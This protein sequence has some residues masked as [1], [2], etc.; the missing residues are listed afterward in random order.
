MQT[1]AVKVRKSASHASH[2]SFERKMGTFQV[3]QAVANAFFFPQKNGTVVN[4]IANINRGFAGMAHTG[5]ARAGVDNLTKSLSVEWAR[6]GIRINS[7]APGIIDSSGLEQYPPELLAGIA[8]K[9]P[10]Q[11]LGTVEEVAE[12]VLFLSSPYAAYITGETV[13]IDGGQRLWG[14]IWSY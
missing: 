9:I 5:A 4:I 1:E 3:T 10:M 14:D 7:V 8:D 12:L 6:R 13:Y 2:A 11:R